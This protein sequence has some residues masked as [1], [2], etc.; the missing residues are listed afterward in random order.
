MSDLKE[1]TQTHIVL[2]SG[3]LD[4]VVNLHCA[5]LVGKVLR[6]ITFNYGQRSVRQEIKAASFFS[7]KIKVQHEV[8]DIPWLA[9]LTN[10]ALVNNKEE[11]PHL[12]NLDD[13]N[14]GNASAK[15]VW[16][17]NRNG[18]FLNIA[19]TFAESLGADFVVPGFNK[20]E[21]ATFLDNSQSFIEATNKAFLLSTMSHVRVKCFTTDL[22][23]TGM[24][25]KA[26]E[27]GV[28]LES[29]WSCYRDVKAP[30][31][32]CESCQRTLRARKAVGV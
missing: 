8:I 20:E 10:T 13:M 11:L 12:K 25:K 23:K 21:A 32:Q 16:V 27:L 17:P 26:V 18:V 24:I 29:V 4:S 5:H 2:L 28:D 15:A 9:K 19:A 22:D 14:E 7:Q 1:P 30:C 6:T 31:G 3:G